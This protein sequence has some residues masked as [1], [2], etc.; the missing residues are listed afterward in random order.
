MGDPMTRSAYAAALLALLVPSAAHAV[1]APQCWAAMDIAPG[2]LVAGSLSYTAGDPDMVAVRSSLGQFGPFEGGSM[3]L[4]STGLAADVTLLQDY[5]WP[6]TFSDPGDRIEITFQ[7]DVPPWANSFFFRHDFFSREYP[8]WVGSSFN[9]TLE[10]NLSGAAWTGQL[11]WDAYGNPITVNNAFFTVTNPVDLTGTGFDQDGS[12]GWLVTI[13]PVQPND[14]I[15]LTFALYD[16]ADGVW[17]SAVLLDDFEWSASQISLPYTS[18]ADADGGF[19]EPPPGWTADGPPPPTA[20]FVSPKDG[21]RAGGVQVAL[22][23]DNLA[24]T[25]QV[26]LGGA[27]A[28]LIDVTPTLATLQ[29]PSAAEAGV[30][31]GGAVDVRVVQGAD[32]VV[33]AGAF[34]YR[35]V[36]GGGT[37]TPPAR[38]D[39]VWPMKVTPGRATELEITGVG[40]LGGAVEIETL[41][42]GVIPLEVLKETETADSQTLSVT[43]PPLLDGVATV[44]V[45]SKGS[46]TRW[47]QVLR[48]ERPGGIELPDPEA[49]GCSAVP[50]GNPDAL[51]LLL[52]ALGVVLTL[53]RRAD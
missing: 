8:E 32:E 53:R 3:C 16:V 19:A 36:E 5:D 22:V 50:R 30:P 26:W 4:L 29:I 9:D 6:G 15:T 2:D 14:V 12:T 52:G 18:H 35:A 28:V 27:P 44:R 45:R 13:A 1:S 20:A 33:L 51:A 31:E 7:L 38:I 46:T 48:I 49:A 40:L 11:A 25:L 43:L 39:L 17:D 42:Q 21:P 10:L 37:H 34:V 23:G 47:D 24:P 41:D